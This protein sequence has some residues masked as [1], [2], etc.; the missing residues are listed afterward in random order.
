MSIEAVRT[1]WLLLLTGTPIQ[2]NMKE[3][4]SIMNL[5]RPDEFDDCD[6]FLHRFGNPPA[7]PSSP[8]QLQ[9]LQAR[10][11]SSV[12]Q[13]VRASTGETTSRE[14]RNPQGHT[15]IIGEHPV[16][17]PWVCQAACGQNT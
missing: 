16:L 17:C 13:C 3:L 14:T 15:H 11:L 2:N 9:D 8:E 6:T 1:Q 5:I 7:V 10:P 4:Y 12:P